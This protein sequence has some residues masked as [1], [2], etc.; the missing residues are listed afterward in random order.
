MNM[1]P[2]D[3][4]AVYTS[5][6]RNANPTTVENLRAMAPLLEQAAALIIP[7]GRLDAIAY[8]CTSATVVIGYQAV[9]EAIHR[10]RPGIPVITPITA[11]VAGLE[12]LGKRR[13]AVLTPYLDEVNAP[14]RRCLEDCGQEVVG[15][16]SFG[17]ADD[18]DMARLPPETIYQAALE[19]DRKDAE[20]L[21]ISCTAIR[22]AEV[23]AR[24]E[25]ALA[26]PVV[27]SIQ[28]LY[29]HALR[30]AGYEEP[31]TGF[32]RLLETAA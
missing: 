4:V 14:M 21:F 10:A 5:R 25:Q 1:R 6:V 27:T 3:D 32:G 28:A 31:I 30:A 9:A 16:T 17:L 11:A 7:A 22:A 24:L 15:F 8:S 20:A 23:A 19:A 13:I 18:N 29:W 26:K 12:A 2:S